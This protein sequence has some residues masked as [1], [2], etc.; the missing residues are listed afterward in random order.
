M[1]SKRGRN[2]SSTAVSDK[3]D[4]D[5]KGS[6][7]KSE[8]ES[9]KKQ[10][11]LIIE[12]ET[13]DGL[14]ISIEPD[15]AEISREYQLSEND[16]IELSVGIDWSPVDFNVEKKGLDLSVSGEIGVPGDLIGFSGGVTLDLGE[17]TISGGELG[18]ELGGVEVSGSIE[19]E[20]GCKK[21][22]G[23]SFLGVGIAYNRDDCNEDE[24]TDDNE[25][26]DDIKQPAGNDGRMSPQ[27]LGAMM[28]NSSCNGVD[29]TICYHR[30]DIWDE[31]TN[32]WINGTRQG[33]M[34]EGSSA[35]NILSN[36]KILGE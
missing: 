17:G 35:L 5:S 29:F 27:D 25:G 22:I 10:L 13:E 18:V 20:K 3:R 32:K 12:Y 11:P 23:I 30:I 33:G 21:S 36:F 2:R 15:E 19:G 14:K 9:E 4:T 26:E 16:S 31:S 34:G 24:D 8:S 1:S 7:Q 6:P 28:P